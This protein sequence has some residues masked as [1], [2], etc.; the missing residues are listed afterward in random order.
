V[1]EAVAGLG[2]EYHGYDEIEAVIAAAG[3]RPPTE[4]AR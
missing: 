2:L 3:G 4:S 1:I